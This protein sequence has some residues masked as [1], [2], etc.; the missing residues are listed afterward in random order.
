M[1]IVRNRA[2][3][4][5]VEPDNTSP[6]W[7]FVRKTQFVNRIATARSKN[8]YPSEWLAVCAYKDGEVIWEPW[9]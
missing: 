3:A 5:D 8:S 9:I 1:N 4:I 7:F 6:G 2:I